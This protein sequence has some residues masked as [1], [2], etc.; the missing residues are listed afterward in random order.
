MVAGENSSDYSTD[1]LNTPWGCDGADFCFYCEFGENSFD[2]SR[3]RKFSKTVSNSFKFVDFYVANPPE[4]L[5]YQKIDLT[6]LNSGK[7][8]L[9]YSPPI[10]IAWLEDGVVPDLRFFIRL[11]EHNIFQVG[12]ASE[13]YYSG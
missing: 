6:A 11:Y 4:D 3:L 12:A 2:L 10:I 9:D 13:Y 5:R 7:L 8:K 1:F